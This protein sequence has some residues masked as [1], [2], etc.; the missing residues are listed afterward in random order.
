MSILYSLQQEIADR[1]TADPFFAAV[2]VLA[3]LPRDMA[4][5][6]QAG[7]AAAGTWGIVL[8]PQAQV[9]SPNAPGPILDPV[10]FAIRFRANVPV[11]AGPG[12]LDAAEAALALLH[13][14]RPPSVNEVLVAAPEALRR[15]IEPNV[16]TYEVRVR[17]QV[18]V[19]YEIP[20]VAAPA[21]SV[22]GADFPLTVSLSCGTPGAAMFYTLDGSA[23]VPRGATAA[24]YSGPL[25]VE[26]GCTLRVRGW[27]AGYLTSCEVQEVLG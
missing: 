20:R 6:L 25:S 8:V 27:L 5:E 4:F 24:L 22:A 17:T 26:A 12:A 10:E 13:L 18:C 2:P 3:E 15:V 16:V 19:S 14:Y 11:S 21:V 23:P 9:S 1:L 7:I